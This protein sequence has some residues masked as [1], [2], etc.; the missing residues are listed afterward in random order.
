MDVVL[1][2]VLVNHVD[3]TANACLD[4]VVREDHVMSQRDRL[5]SIA[6]SALAH[7][8]VATSADPLVPTFS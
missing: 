4:V 1:A 3:F 2:S 5:Q 7:R 8:I 6:I